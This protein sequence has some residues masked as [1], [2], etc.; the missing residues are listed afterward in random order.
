MDLLIKICLLPFYIAFWVFKI[1][2]RLAWIV[3]VAFLMLL[4]GPLPYSRPRRRRS[5]WHW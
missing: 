1:M 2:L 5:Y 4:F 3:I